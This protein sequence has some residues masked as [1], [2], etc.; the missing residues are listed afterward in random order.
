[1]LLATMLPPVPPEVALW[2]FFEERRRCG[3]LDAGVEDGDLWMV[4]ECG[5]QM[6]PAPLLLQD[7]R[8]MLHEARQQPVRELPAAL[9]IR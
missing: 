2:A 1:M 4:R 5:A 6:H 7:R 9:A 3:E 8:R